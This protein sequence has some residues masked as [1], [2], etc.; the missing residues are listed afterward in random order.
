M[1]KS[2][3]MCFGLPRSGK[4]TW[5]ASQIKDGVA[6]VNPDSIRLALHGQDFVKEAE[7]MVWA[8][9]KYM[10]E[11]LFLA[12]HDKVL[13]DSTNAHKSDRDFWRTDKWTRV[14]HHFTTPKEVCIQRA[15]RDEREYLIPVIEKMAIEF[16]PITLFEEF[17]DIITHD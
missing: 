10:V 2:L 14:C 15:K 5:T 17:L 6:I 1:A 4:S 11:A 3:I 13:L 8:I 9:A 7:P 12:G 16:E